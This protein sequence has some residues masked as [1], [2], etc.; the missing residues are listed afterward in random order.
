MGLSPSLEPGA[1][2][3]PTS[4]PT[5]SPTLS[6]TLGPSLSPTL[7]PILSPSAGAPTLSPT[8]SPTIS[9]TAS[10]TLSPTLSPSISPTLGPTLVPADVCL[11]QVQC[12]ARREQ[13]GIEDR[14]Y[15]VGNYPSYGCFQKNGKVYWGRGG[16]T[17]EKGQDPLPGVRERM[18]C[19]SMKSPTGSPT[20]SLPL[21]PTVGP[22]LSPSSNDPGGKTPAPSDDDGTDI[23]VGTVTTSNDIAEERVVERAPNDLPCLSE[24]TKT[25][26]ACEQSWDGAACTE[27]CRDIIH[28]YCGLDFDRKEKSAHYWRNCPDE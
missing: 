5:V 9:P 12:D 14:N 3:E 16:T 19:P 26:T 27:K 18:Y 20:Q 28:I 23:T 2:R 22:T 7:S 25:F 10:P 13:L 8:V 4:S 6:P 24:T 21:S 11:T 15:Y 1:T 17:A